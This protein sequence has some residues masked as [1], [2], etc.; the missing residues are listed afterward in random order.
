MIPFAKGNHGS[1]PAQTAS[2][3]GVSRGG[4]RGLRLD[5]SGAPER[6]EANVIVALTADPAFAGVLAFDDFSQEVVVRQPLPWDAATGTFPRPWVDADDTRTAEWLQLRGINIA[7]V[8]VS[9]AVGAVARERR[10]HPVRDWLDT[11]TWDGTPRI[12][13]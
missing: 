7:P 11:L 3:S 9:R 13:T 6:N 10:I 1:T 12:G 8:V 2:E 5:L 4:I